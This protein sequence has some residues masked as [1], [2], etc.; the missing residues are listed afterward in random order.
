VKFKL[1]IRRLKRKLFFIEVNALS[2]CLKK[3]ILPYSDVSI[4]LFDKNFNS[5]SLLN[6]ERNFSNWTIVIQG[7]VGS[8]SELKY[9]KDSLNILRSNYRGV[10]IVLS[11]YIEYKNYVD[12]LDNKLLDHIILL[13][14]NDYV[15]NFERQVASSSIG[16]LQAKTWGTPFAIKLRTDQKLRNPVCLQLF[17]TL[18]E[19]FKDAKT[20]SKT[21][22][23]F[24]SYN[25]W[26]YRPFGLSDMFTAGSTEE[27]NKYWNFNDDVTNFQI[28]FN[29][30]PGWLKNGVLFFESFLSM[31]FL[32]FY[33]FPFCEDKFQDSADAL[34]N[35]FIVV[36]STSIGQEWLKRDN[37]WSGNSIIKAGFNLP[38][39]AL[40]ELNFS[41]W[42]LIKNK[43]LTIRAN[44]LASRH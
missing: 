23:I 27:L 43:I 28:K 21:R 16:L 38:P 3:V 26:L 39:E 40:I 14:L 10:K 33:N 20:A 42:L 15:N 2:A 1:F 4:S 35:Y 18:L 19:E 25:S 22:I 44:E 17:E 12:Q 9:L 6:Y 36:D 8:N 30:S 32:N 7:P 24:G 41:T 29:H 11:T 37:V 34:R 13:N 31:R 5:Y